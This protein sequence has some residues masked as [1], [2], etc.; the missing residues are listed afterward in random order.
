MLP[1]PVAADLNG[2]GRMEVI[3][4][5]HDAKLQVDHEFGHCSS[6][7]MNLCSAQVEPLCRRGQ[8]AHCWADFVVLTTS[9]DIL[10][11]WKLCCLLQVLGPRRHGHAG[12]G[13][14]KAALLA[15]V[16]L[17][18]EGPN[19]AL[20]QHRAVALATGYLDPKHNELVRALR[21]QV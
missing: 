8:P 6:P 19:E 3:T 4:A 15:E 11:P 16:S 9:A 7:Q 18:P 21:K 10:L 5:T 20:A 17:A 1:P 13:F 14:A 2:D 12:E